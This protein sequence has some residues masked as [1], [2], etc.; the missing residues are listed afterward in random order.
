MHR[1][2]SC[3][4]TRRDATRRDATRN[5]LTATATRIA[6]HIG[7]H[8]EPLRRNGAI[9]RSAPA[10][11]CA[12]VLWLAL[13]IGGSPLHSR[14]ALAQE[15]P[16]HVPAAG[17]P[18]RGA[19]RLP[20]EEP[21]VLTPEESARGFVARR[22][23]FKARQREREER[24]RREGPRDYSIPPPPAAAR[25]FPRPDAP[26]G[27]L[28]RQRRGQPIDGLHGRESAAEAVR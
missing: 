1:P 7:A 14:F 24:R 3:D 8:G 28:D 9:V 10:V 20:F 23:R 13:L 2:D 22:E 15:A 16:R 19:P 26:G 25:T 6:G 27:E 4:A 11:L 17:E 18:Q 5:A 21:P 12:L